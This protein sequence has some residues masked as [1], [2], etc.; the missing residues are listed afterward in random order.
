[1]RPRVL[2]AAPG[3]LFALRELW[4]LTAVAAAE[5][6]T[7]C[8]VTAGTVDVV[9][10][11]R[12]E[13]ALLPGCLDALGWHPALHSIVLVDDGSTD[14]TALVARSRGVRVVDAGQRPSGWAG[15]AWALDRGTEA[16]VA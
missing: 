3:T 12:D 14:G 1:M 5:L 8:P 11:A 7:G 9:I 16:S 2:W 10:P 4:R 15:K 13:E 6:P